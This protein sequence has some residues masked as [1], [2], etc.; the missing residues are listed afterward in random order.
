MRASNLRVP[1]A[2]AV[3]A[4][5]AVA[6]GACSDDS[7]SE[8]S[9]SPTAAESTADEFTDGPAESP[10][11]RVSET[12]DATDGPTDAPS[13]DRG[14]STDGPTDAPAPDVGD[15]TDGPTDG[16]SSQ[17]LD[18]AERAQEWLVALVNADPVVCDYVLNT[19]GD[20]AMSDSDADLDLCENVLLADAEEAFDEEI[21]AIM[22]AVSVT[23]AEVDASGEE[24]VVDGRHVSDLFASALGEDRIVLV[25]IDGEWLVDLD[26]S[27]RTE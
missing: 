13:P 22:G 24:A 6:I 2:A 1:A 27:F 18:A 12:A 17:A 16:P 20:G 23:G 15:A 21:A 4:V 11:D 25:A 10:D 5:A 14:D 26:R 9:A 8:E 19:A 7:S 3:T